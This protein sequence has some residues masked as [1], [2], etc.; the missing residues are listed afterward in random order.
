MDQL[1]GRLKAGVVCFRLARSLLCLALGLERW[2]ARRSAM[3]ALPHP[4]CCQMEMYIRWVCEMGHGFVCHRGGKFGAIIKTK[5][6]GGCPEMAHNFVC[7]QQ[8]DLSCLTLLLTRTYPK[9]SLIPHP[10]VLN[11]TKG[12]RNERRIAED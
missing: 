3:K 10:N 7:L 11:G 12:V 2:Q 6:E 8:T 5:M 1:S 4:T 9:G